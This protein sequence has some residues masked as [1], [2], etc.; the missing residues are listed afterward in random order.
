MVEVNDMAANCPVVFLKD[1][2]TGR[3]RLACLMGFAAGENLFVQNGAWGATHLPMA[4]A[5]SPFLIAELSDGSLGPALDES[6]SMVNSSEGDALYQNGTETPFL[7]ARKKD[8]ERLFHAEAETQKF[9]EHVVAE[10]LLKAMVLEL[11][12]E[13]GEQR[14]LVGLYTVDGEALQQLSA[15]KLEELN[16]L[17]FLTAL[18]VMLGSLAQMKRLVNLKNAD[19]GEKLVALDVH[20]TTP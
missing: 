13:A 1:Q 4:L 8:L 18:H 5:T 17:G 14:K 11:K 19:G 3:F 2:N 16:K 6:S 10:R 20:A 9:T 7:Q 15:A 12:L